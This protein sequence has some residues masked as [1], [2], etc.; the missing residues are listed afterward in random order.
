M[1]GAYAT[2]SW[3]HSSFGDKIVKATAWRDQGLPISIVAES[4]WANFL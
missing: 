3:K 4:H 1:I 2:E